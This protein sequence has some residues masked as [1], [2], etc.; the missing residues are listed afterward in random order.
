MKKLN[1]YFW[2]LLKI[3]YRGMHWTVFRIPTKISVLSYLK[4]A[5]FEGLFSP[6]SSWPLPLKQYLDFTGKHVLYNGKYCLVWHFFREIMCLGVSPSRPND[7]E[8][9]ENIPWCGKLQKHCR[10]NCWW[11]IQWQNSGHQMHFVLVAD[12]CFNLLHPH[13]VSD[14][15]QCDLE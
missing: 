4:F 2:D 5:V 6:T 13:S 10:R 3:C 1:W 8:S 12:S 15:H 9:S 7:S 11:L 14:G